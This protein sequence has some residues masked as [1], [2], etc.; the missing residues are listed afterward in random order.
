MERQTEKMYLQF[1]RDIIRILL[2]RYTVAHRTYR[3]PELEYTQTYI[4]TKK[5]YI[6][7]IKIMYI[8]VRIPFGGR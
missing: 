7:P 8:R 4:Q 5:M 6:I 2:A 1:E 3:A